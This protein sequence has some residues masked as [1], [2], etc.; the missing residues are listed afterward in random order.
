MYTSEIRKGMITVTKG[1]LDYLK[2]QIDGGKTPEEAIE[3]LN[4]WL[5]LASKVEDGE[6]GDAL[7]NHI[8]S[9]AK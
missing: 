7:M 9:E 8:V 6:V 2:K 1:N 4:M 5:N 3:S